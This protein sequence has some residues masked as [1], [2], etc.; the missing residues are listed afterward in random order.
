MLPLLLGAIYTVNRCSSRGQV[1][2]KEGKTSSLSSLF[3]S[4]PRKDHHAKISLLRH[5]R[6]AAGKAG[7]NPRLSLGYITHHCRT[8]SPLPF[9]WGERLPASDCRYKE[10]LMFSIQH[11]RRWHIYDVPP[12]VEREREEVLQNL[13]LVT[14]TGCLRAQGATPTLNKGQKKR[15]SCRFPGTLHRG[16]KGLEPWKPRCLTRTLFV[17]V[18]SGLRLETEISLP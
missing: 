6:Q 9:G 2:G 8:L 16:C 3:R 12:S 7:R 5:T 14:G 15:R 1:E 18:C 11:L 17:P 10:L 13:L 4:Y